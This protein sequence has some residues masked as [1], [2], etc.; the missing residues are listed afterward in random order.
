M[1]RIIIYTSKNFVMKVKKENCVFS[2]LIF[3]Y[4]YKNQDLP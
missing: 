4:S 1:N 2:F 3:T